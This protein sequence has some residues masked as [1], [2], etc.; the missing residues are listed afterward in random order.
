MEGLI[1]CHLSDRP[2]T[3]F[4]EGFPAFFY[5]HQG[6]GVGFDVLQQATEFK[7]VARKWRGGAKMNASL[8]D[9][10]VAAIVLKCVEDLVKGSKWSDVVEEDFEITRVGTDGGMGVFWF[11]AEETRAI[12]GIAGIVC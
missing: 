6:A 2:A 7:R 9:V 11:Y 3:D 1:V 8:A 5:R 4:C 12:F 10:A